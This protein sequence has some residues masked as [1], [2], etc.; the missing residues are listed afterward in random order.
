M[1]PNV[2]IFSI[3]KG[4]NHNMFKREQRGTTGGDCTALYGV[5]LDHHYTLKEFVNE[6]LQNYPGEWGSFKLCERGKWMPYKAFRYKHGILTD[7]IPSELANKPIV[8]ISAN[9]GWSNMDYIIRMEESI[10]G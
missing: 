3:R 8:S 10:N 7:A 5:E 6:V 2:Y 4:D 1:I 9:G